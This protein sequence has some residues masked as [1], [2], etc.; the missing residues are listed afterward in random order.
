[1]QIS[2][3]FVCM[4]GCLLKNNL[5]SNY[6]LQRAFEI[7]NAEDYQIDCLLIT[8]DLVEVTLEVEYV[9]LKQILNRLDCNTRVLSWQAR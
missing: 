1:M 6:A 5:D 9:Y 7:I 2:D 3:P 4:P 8:G